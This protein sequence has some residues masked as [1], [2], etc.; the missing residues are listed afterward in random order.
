MGEWLRA[1]AVAVPAVDDPDRAPPVRRPQ[2]PRLS[3]PAQSVPLEEKSERI[4]SH[5][6]Q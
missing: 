2:P 1:G 6:V 3:E 5:G 4:S